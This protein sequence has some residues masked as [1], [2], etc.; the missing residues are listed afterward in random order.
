MSISPSLSSALGSSKPGAREAVPVDKLLFVC[1][2][3]ICRSPMA[4]A[5]A[6]A[7]LAGRPYDVSVASAG[8]LQEGLVPPGDAVSA[9]AGRGLDVG[10]HRSRSLAL[11]LSSPPPLPDL[12][13]G[14]A[15]GHAREAIEHDPEQFLSRTFTLK[16]LVRRAAAAG[17]RA[18]GEVLAGYLIRIGADRRVADL[19]GLSR[20]DD[21][22]DPIGLGAAAFRR[23]AAEIEDLVFA[24]VDLV[25]PDVPEPRGQPRT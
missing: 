4:E 19:V 13:V 20:A 7:R 18:A 5:F 16:D 11:M 1:T 21:V 17:P 25:W 24:M 22:A 15:R 9:M 3:N 23:S 12:V 6:R 14:M 10:A 2:G 8:L